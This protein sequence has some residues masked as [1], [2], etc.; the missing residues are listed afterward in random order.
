M[1]HIPG[2]KKNIY[3]CKFFFNIIYCH[4]R[5]RTGSADSS[6]HHVEFDVEKL[7]QDIIMEMKKEM[8]KIKLELIEGKFIFKDDL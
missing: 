8:N 3:K 5:L 4:Y 7:K 1:I 6:S 2:N